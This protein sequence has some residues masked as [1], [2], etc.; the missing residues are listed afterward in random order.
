MKQLNT[1]STVSYANF[2]R[3]GYPNRV[4]FQAI[5]D[6][7]K[8]IENNLKNI[9]KNPSE[10]YTKV[11]LSIGFKFNDFQLGKD[12]IFFRSEKFSLVTEFLSESSRKFN[13]K[14]DETSDL[15]R[16]PK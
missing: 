7:C 9:C 3:F 14:N 6:A 4:T 5:S 12:V 13:E 15:V 2:V 11:I 1:S 8:S 10:F 16:R